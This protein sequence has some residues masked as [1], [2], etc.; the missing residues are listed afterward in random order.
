M[1]N[2]SSPVGDGKPYFLGPHAL[3]KF[4]TGEEGMGPEVFWLVDKENHTIRPFESNMAL[5]AAFGD[6][7]EKALSNVMTITPPQMDSSGEIMD[8]IL[9]DFTIL[10]PEYSIMEDGTAK[11]MDFSPHQLKKRYGKPIDEQKE[12]TAERTLEG[13]LNKLSKN[14]SGSDMTS[15]FVNKLKSDMQLMAFYIS[16]LAYGGYDEN[17]I[18]ADILRRFDRSKE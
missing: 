6:D 7:L 12:S 3:I 5:D 2:N 16:S 14:E 4:S 13:L 1:E 11:P 17:D 10:G 8:G 18:H 15:K 9:A